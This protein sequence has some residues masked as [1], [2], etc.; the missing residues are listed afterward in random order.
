MVRNRKTV[1]PAGHWRKGWAQGSGQHQTIGKKRRADK[2]A[3]T[4]R[5]DDMALL[6]RQKLAAEE[7]KLAA[8]Q[9][10]DEAVAASK[11]AEAQAR[12]AKAAGLRALNVSAHALINMRG[13][14]KAIAATGE[15]ARDMLHGDGVGLRGA[16]AMNDLA[17]SDKVMRWEKGEAVAVEEAKLTSMY[18]DLREKRY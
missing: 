4:E 16:F 1:L 13:Q 2:V 7:K 9:Q 18:R 3:P 5:D 10:R 14:Y 17:R 12:E 15:A 8:E 6:A 11:A